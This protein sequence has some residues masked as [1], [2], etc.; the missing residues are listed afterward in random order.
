MFLLHVSQRSLA[1]QESLAC[2][3]SLSL[4]L[5]WTPWPGAKCVCSLLASLK[6]DG[7]CQPQQRVT[8]WLA[9]PPTSD[10]AG[11]YTTWFNLPFFH[12]RTPYV[13]MCVCARACVCVC[14]CVHVCVCVCLELYY[15]EYMCLIRGSGAGKVLRYVSIEGGSWKHN[16]T[17]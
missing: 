1:L 5:T 17:L 15:T 11:T 8:V 3:P 10:P 6:F 9:S 12:I 14:V 2:S 13:C 7:S 4:P 16:H